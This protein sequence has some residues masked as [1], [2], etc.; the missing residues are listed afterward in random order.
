[1]DWLQV[2]TI[3]LSVFGLFLWARRETSADRRETQS[4]L[5]GDR[6]DMD[7]KLEANKDLINSIHKETTDLIRDFHYKLIEIE[8]NR[9]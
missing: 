4:I 8:K 2:F 7:E 1:M 3:V 6:K 5:R 9:R